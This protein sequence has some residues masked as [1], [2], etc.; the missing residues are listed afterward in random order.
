MGQDTMHA[1][2]SHCLGNLLLP[3]GTH[4]FYVLRHGLLLY[5]TFPEELVF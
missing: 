3:Y 4:L 1:S 2:P 5:V